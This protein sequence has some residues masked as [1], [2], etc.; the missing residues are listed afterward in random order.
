MTVSVTMGRFIVKVLML[1]LLHWLLLLQLLLLRPC[2]KL[3]VV[4]VAVKT[5]ADISRTI[6]G[7]GSS[8]IHRPVAGKNGQR[9][10]GGCGRSRTQKSAVQN[11]ANSVV[12]LLQLTKS[13][14]DRGWH[15]G[16]RRLGAKLFK[17]F[18][19]A[20]FRLPI[21]PK[22]GNLQIRVLKF[23]SCSL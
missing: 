11:P 4:S 20:E 2:A 10:S 19:V 5:T 18:P 6:S 16:Y 7:V 15:P 22:F 8:A 14:R 17:P 23:R 13:A 3:A 12:L 21:P 9:G 1:L